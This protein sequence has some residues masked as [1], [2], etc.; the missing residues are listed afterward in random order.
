MGWETSARGEKHNV[1]MKRTC[2]IAPPAHTSAVQG[3]G[4]HLKQ[5]RLTK[6]CTDT[7]KESPARSGWKQPASACQT[8]CMTTT[9]SLADLLPITS[10]QP[11][12][13]DL[14]SQT[15]PLPCCSL[16]L[17]PQSTV[18]VLPSDSH[19]SGTAWRVTGMSHVGTPFQLGQGGRSREHH[20][21]LPRSED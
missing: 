20:L 18:W 13:E 14:S 10:A 16:S 9:C 8:F 11:L 2:R 15:S 19:T 4:P 12:N 17:M 21:L 6:G 1:T 7:S 3:L 5:V